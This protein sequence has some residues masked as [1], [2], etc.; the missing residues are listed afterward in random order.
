MHSQEQIQLLLENPI[1]QEL[2]EI[3]E[4][5]GK[6]VLQHLELSYIDQLFEQR[7]KTKKGGPIHQVI[8]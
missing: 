6:V 2:L 5:E 4:N 1:V 7:K 3:L 8:T